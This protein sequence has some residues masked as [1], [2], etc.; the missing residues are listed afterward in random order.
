MKSSGPSEPTWTL[1]GW[2]GIYICWKSNFWMM[3]ATLTLKRVI[4]TNLLKN[5]LVVFNPSEKY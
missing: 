3:K 4:G 1:E 5:W 2:Y